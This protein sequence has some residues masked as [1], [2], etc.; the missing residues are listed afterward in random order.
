MKNSFYLFAI[1]LFVLGL[2]IG[3][4]AAGNRP[5]SPEITAIESSPRS[6][7]HTMPDG[8]IMSGD[9]MTMESMMADMNAELAK[10]QGADL[11][12]SFI[13]EMI[14]HHQGAIDMAQILLNGTER[15]ELI[16]LSEDIITAQTNEIEMMNT[17]K[18]E[19][20]GR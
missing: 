2:G 7:A 12:L 5:S 13:N 20:F 8:T 15:P 1:V 9:G 4:A 10:K 11:E 18:R 14:V 16:K 17:W 19:W 3:Y 6:S